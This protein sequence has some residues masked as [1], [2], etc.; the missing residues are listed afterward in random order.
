M[1][2]EVRRLRKNGTRLPREK[3]GASQT[4]R[5]ELVVF[6]R[7]DPWRNMLV[8][9]AGLVG[10]DGDTYLLPP[11]DHVRIT[12]WRGSDLVLVG[13]EDEGFRKDNREQLQAWWV[14]LVSDLDE[15]KTPQ[16]AQA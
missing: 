2:A 12:R 16:L 1:L 7:R 6:K 14:R 8:P 11:L 4:Y 13:L 3:V 9:V 5:G 15:Q 10:K